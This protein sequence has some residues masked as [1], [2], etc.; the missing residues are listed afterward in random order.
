MDFEEIKNQ[1]EYL[2]DRVITNFEKYFSYLVLEDFHSGGYNDRIADEFFYE[3]YFSRYE[4]AIRS[5]LLLIGNNFS[6]EYADFE[7][8]LIKMKRVIDSKL[9]K[10][11]ETSDISVRNK[12]V[13]TFL[14]SDGI[15]KNLFIS[16]FYNLLF[17]NKLIDINQDD[18]NLHFNDDWN[19]IK[20]LGT[21]I[22]ITNLISSLI[23]KKFL[24]PETNNSKY[25]LISAHFINKNGKPFNEKQLGSVYSEKKEFIPNDDIVLKIIKKL[26][27]TFTS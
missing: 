19:K 6:E 11:E 17:D 22:Q 4:D 14:I 15:D 10:S 25:K 24:D 13:V 16:A 21:E 9:L 5:L 3:E 2:E 18:F 23:D 1:V 8:R 20:W 12:R 26:V 27:L 7:L